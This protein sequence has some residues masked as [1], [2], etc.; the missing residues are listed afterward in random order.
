MIAFKS[1]D[2]KKKWP[3][4]LLVFCA[5]LGVLVTTNNRPNMSNFAY[6]RA[7]TNAQVDCLTLGQDVI[8]SQLEHA[9][10]IA[11][12]YCAKSFPVSSS[13]T[14]KIAFFRYCKYRQ[15]ELESSNQ[16]GAL[17]I[18]MFAMMLSAGVCCS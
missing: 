11:T 8:Q 13:C 7:Y 5:G 10:E 3:I 14:D 9:Q 6:Y 1:H 2:L 18:L 4:F 16:V 17:F 15:K 12:G